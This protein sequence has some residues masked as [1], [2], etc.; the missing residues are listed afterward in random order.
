MKK[1]NLLVLL[2]GLI[3]IS[4]MSSCDT[5]EEPGEENPTIVLTPSGDISAVEGDSVS[6]TATLG[7]NTLSKSNLESFEVDADGTSNDTLVE[8][9]NN[10]TN[11]SFTF[12]VNAPVAGQQNTVTFTLTDKA[13]KT[14]A[15]TVKI[16]GA[17]ALSA[18]TAFGVEG[19][20]GILGI[21]LEQFGLKWSS[22][23][24]RF[25]IVK[26]HADNKLVS[27]STTDWTNLITK[28][29]L[30][31]A[32]D[33]AVDISPYVGVSE[34]ASGTYGDVIATKK[35][36]DYYLINVKVG[37]VSGGGTLRPTIIGNYKK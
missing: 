4:F 12:E 19:V 5:T 8:Y 27:L 26:Q 25:V 20:P 28:E 17:T 30:K 9:P 32:V 14:A 6:I 16:T 35:G 7:R 37:T 29:D 3:A 10:T 18:P 31:D 24:S 22:D 33:S 1:L 23:Y 13:G 34:T 2:L 11:E 15:K 21:G 36:N